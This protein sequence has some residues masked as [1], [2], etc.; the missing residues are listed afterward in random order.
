MV[1]RLELQTCNNQRSCGILPFEIIHEGFTIALS[2]QEWA[3]Y[4]VL[5]SRLLSAGHVVLQLL[6]RGDERRACRWTGSSLHPVRWHHFDQRPMPPVVLYRRVSHCTLPCKAFVLTQMVAVGWSRR[7][8]A[9]CVMSPLRMLLVTVV[10]QTHSG[11]SGVPATTR[12]GL[13]AKG[14]RACRKRT[15]YGSLAWPSLS[16]WP[17]SPRFSSASRDVAF[18]LT[19]S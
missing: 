13:A 19:R 14:S 2:T 15:C 12:R 7:W 11:L 10:S 18:I 17:C 3:V 1:S 16:R 4:C 8:M 9:S 6:P 5:H